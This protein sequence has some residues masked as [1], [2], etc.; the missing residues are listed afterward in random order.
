MQQT[1]LSPVTIS[2][3]SLIRI[4]R[5][6]KGHSLVAVVMALD[7]PQIDYVGA[8]P[9]P[10]LSR[11]VLA[12]RGPLVARTSADIVGHTQSEHVT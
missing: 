10:S 6:A 8:A 5:N 12:F 1:G 11:P 7:V 4:T 2:K 9:V 3:A